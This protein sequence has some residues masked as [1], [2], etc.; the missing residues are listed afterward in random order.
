MG[1]Q[2]RVRTFLDIDIGRIRRLGRPS[3]NI[4]STRSANTTRRSDAENLGLQVVSTSVGF[5]V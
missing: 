5:F 2:Q 4:Y 1:R 3:Q